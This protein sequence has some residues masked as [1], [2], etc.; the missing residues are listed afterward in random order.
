M[1]RDHRNCA[2]LDLSP[3]AFFDRLEQEVGADR[4]VIAAYTARVDFGYLFADGLWIQ[5]DGDCT[6][7]AADF[8]T[9]NADGRFASLAVIWTA[10]V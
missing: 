10:P 1:L 6:L 3:S 2:Q 5:P 7:Q 8:F 4:F 9:G